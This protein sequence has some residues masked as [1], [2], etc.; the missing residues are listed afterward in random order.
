VDLRQLV[1]TDLNLLVVLWVLFEEQSVSRAAERLF[2]TQSAVSK[3]LS[4]LRALLDDPLFTR[5]GYGLVATPYLEALAPKLIQVLNGVGGLLEPV[6]FDPQVSRVQIRIACSQTVEMIVMPWLLAYLQRNAPS[7]SVHSAHYDS[8][9]LQR[10]AQ[11][12][13]DF[14]ISM[15]Y[16]Q[17]P[18]DFEIEN[19][20]TSSPAL[21]ARKGHPLSAKVIYP[22]DLLSYPRL[23]LKM[24][25]EG[26]TELFQNVYD[27]QRAIVQGWQVAFE[28]ENLITA[29]SI[30]RVTDSLLPGPDVLSKMIVAASDLEVLRVQPFASEQ[31]NF[32][33][34]NHRRTHSSAMHQWFRSVLLAIGEQTMKDRGQA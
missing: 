31:L 32:V 13:L 2:V 4:R 21:F 24:P 22:D 16:A 27:K 6:E 8:D 11:G 20:I 29:L 33:L 34:V 26:L 18:D 7:V 3:S 5:G 10:L 28:T 23:K 19:F 15:E 17:Y 14:A 9:I 25:D 30:A 1:K 12:E